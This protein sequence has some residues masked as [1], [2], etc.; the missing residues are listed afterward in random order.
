MSTSPRRALLVIDV[1][2]EYV[3]G[4]LRI[5]YPP[6]DG[7]LDRIGRA[8][9]AARAAGL[10]IVVVQNSAPATSP[11]FAAGSPGW[12]LHA[13]VAGR[14]HDLRVEKTLPSAFTETGLEDWLRVRGIDTVTVAGFMTHNCD[15]STIVD[16]VHRGFSAEF[17]V[18][19]SGSVPYRN[20][21]GEASAQDIHRVFAVVL[22]SRFAAVVDTTTWA[23]AVTRGERLERG[24]IHASH[25]AALAAQPA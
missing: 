23:A 4:K 19:A 11:L 18:D 7:A 3:S 24:G 5:A 6:V 25:Q 10:P 13:V 17:L 15:A 1:Q 16:A 8:M 14:A 21:A 20:A 9:D 2:N 22:H 12:A